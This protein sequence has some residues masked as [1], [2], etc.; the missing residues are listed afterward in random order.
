MEIIKHPAITNV[1]VLLMIFVRPEK[2]SESFRALKEAR[3]SKLLIVSDGPRLTHPNDKKLN[4]K[5]KNIV[6]DIDWECEVFYKYSEVNQGMYVTAYEGLKWAFSQVD[7]LIFLEDDVVPNQSFFPFCEELLEKYKD[8]LR[9]HTI[10]GMNHAGIYK[11]PPYDY[12]FAKSGS[13]WGFALWKRT[14]DTFDYDL[15]FSL[16]P[17]S[18]NLLIQSYDKSYRKSVKEMIL[19]KRK[20]FEDNDEKGDFEL[21]NGASFFLQHG[22]MIIPTKNMISCHGISENASHNVNHPL[23]LPKSLRRLFYMKTYELNFP[24]KHPKYVIAD[25]DYEKLVL[26]YMGKNKLVRLSRR[27]EGIIRRLFYGVIL[28]K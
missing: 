16:D 8:D 13:I 27:V 15:N 3:P 1:P 6:L 21:I 24:I 26:N 11:P 23:K 28:K 19:N 25:S 5:C 9:I 22:L 14:F 10:C 12:F 20:K 17:Y 2:L 4:E 7:K 18:L